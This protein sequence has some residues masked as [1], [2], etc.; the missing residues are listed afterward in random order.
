MHI[1][2]EHWTYKTSWL[3]LTEQQRSEFLNQI[4][5]SM[6]ELEKAGVTTLGWGETDHTTDQPI[7]YDFIALW[8]G[9]TEAALDLMLETIK[10]SGWYDYFD[11]VNTRTCLTEPGPILQKHILA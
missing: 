2:I 5:Q 8:Q 3:A 7:P 4:G 9:E 10:K 6:A 1:L 11:H